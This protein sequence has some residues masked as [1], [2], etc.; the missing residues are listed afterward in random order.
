[1]GAVPRL[2]HLNGPP[3][4]GKSAL[5]RRW[6]EEHPRTLVCEIDALRTFVSGWQQD[7]AGTGSRI[8]TSALAFITAYLG[9]GGDVVLPQLVANPS[10]LERFV[11][12]VRSGGGDYV[13]VVLTADVDEIIRR[14]HTRGPEHPWSVVVGEL[15]DST[16][17][18][19][20]IRDLATRVEALPG[21]RVESTDLAS[22]YDALV[23][24]VERA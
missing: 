6:G 17:G 20:A 8:R 19:D 9:D 24:A 12:A 16:G 14:H 13:H 7:F 18:D 11:S 4:V 23:A 3:G 15:I 5:A 1:V 22:T 10:E 2:I 21:I